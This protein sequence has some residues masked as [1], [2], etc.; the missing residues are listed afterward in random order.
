MEKDKKNTHDEVM[1][2]EAYEQNFM[3][4]IWLLSC[5]VRGEKP[6]K[7]RCEK[8]DLTA[9]CRLS[10]LHGLDAVTAEAVERA[11]VENELFHRRKAYAIKKAMLYDAERQRILQEF[12]KEG[13]WHVLL[14]GVVLKEFYPGY[15]LRQMTDNDLLIDESR[16]EDVK[17]I[18][19]RLG[20]H[21]DEY[22]SGYHDIY[23]KEPVYSFEMH[24]RLFAR[25]HKKNLFEYYQEIPKRLIKDEDNA[26]GYH[27]SP[28]DFYLYMIAHEYKHYSREG[29][30]LR[31]MLD[32]YLFLKN[33]QLDMDYVCA[34]A[35]KLDIAEF[36]RDNRE[37]SLHLFDGL[38]LSEKEQEMLNYVMH[39][40]Y[41][42]SVDNMVNNKCKEEGWTAMD[43]SL[44][45][46]SVPFRKTDP[47]YPL[48][49][50]HYPFF[51]KHKILLPLLPIYRI[52]LSIRGGRF[53]TEAKAIKKYGEGK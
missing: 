44:H 20:Y 5:L 3:N 41:A 52:F 29:V 37:L 10:A 22:G 11:G 48:F 18:M 23:H 53:M 1:T 7:E 33:H 32:T 42:G 30:G 36:E 16:E 4:M 8:L 2:A 13:I 47:R 12:E 38:A 24:V 51:Y 40:T 46:F 35:E 6:D 9:I 34:E 27:L 21:T 31:A 17:A 19:E 14:K 45:R 28:E 50:R 25:F 39:S 26:Y 15:G 49:E 43:Y